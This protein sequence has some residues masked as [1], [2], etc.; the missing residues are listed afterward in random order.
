MRKTFNI[1]SLTAHAN[2]MLLNLPDEDVSAR[3]A[4]INL[5]TQTLHDA[6]SYNGFTYLDTT[7][8]KKSCNGTTVGINGDYGI[9][10]D[11]DARF[12]STDRTRVKYF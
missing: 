11:Y 12:E 9:G 10:L 7:D 1:E 3:H 4:I 2:A 5:L 6:G 8:M